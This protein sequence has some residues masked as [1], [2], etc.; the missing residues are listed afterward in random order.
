[1]KKVPIGLRKKNLLVGDLSLNIFSQKKGFLVSEFLGKLVVGRSWPKFNRDKFYH[2][3]Q[4]GRHGQVVRV[5][6]VSVIIF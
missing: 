2:W 3:S 4:R 1:M 5:L 6:A